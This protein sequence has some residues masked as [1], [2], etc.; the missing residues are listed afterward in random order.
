[1][2]L[3]H[4]CTVQPKGP[5]SLAA[6]RF[7]VPVRISSI[8]VFPAGAHPFANAPDIVAET[9]P[10]AFYIDVF[11]NAHPIPQADAKEKPR[12]PNA[13]V[14][15]LIAYAGG[16]VEYTVD[17][18]TEH[19]TRLMILKGK[20]TKLS[21]AIYGDVVSDV[22]P[23]ERHEARPLPSVEPV[24]LSKAIDPSSSSDPT[25]L[26]KKL[27]ALMPD[28]PPLPL[29][30]RLMFCLK[31]S[32]DD[33]DLPDF[34]YLHADLESLDD[35][36]LSIEAINDLLS[37]PVHD[38]VTE[39]E[40]SAFAAKVAECISS[41]KDSNDA[42]P[43]AR[44]FSI[45]A[46]QHPGLVRA[47]LRN[48]D[49][50]SFFTAQ[51]VDEETLLCL[52]QAASNVDIARHMNT[53]T[54]LLTLRQVQESQKAEAP[55]QKAARRLA[56]RI[57][58]WQFFEDSLT[59]TQGD[60][61]QCWN[62]L[63]DIGTEESSMAI[64]LETMITHDDIVA[65]MAKIPVKTSL[66][67]HFP[68]YFRSKIN[69][70]S[71]DAFIALVRTLI[72]VASVLAVWAWTDSVGNDKSRE[73]VSAVIH[74][75]QGV[76]GYREIVNHLLLL[77]QLARRLSWISSD[78]EI[79]RQSGILAE[80][81]ICELAKDPQAVLNDD[82][83]NTILQLKPKLAFITENELLSLRKIALVSDDGLPSAAEE[84][85]FSSDHPLS[86]RRL[87]TLRVSLA[88]VKRELVLPKGEWKILESL[89]EE[90]SPG[91]VQ[92][93]IDLLI[94]ISDDLNKQFAL[95]PPPPMNQAVAEQ[96]FSTADD[97]LQL[98]VQLA[99][100][101]P[102]TTRTMRRLVAATADIFACTDAA[103]TLFSQTSP[104]SLSARGTHQGC[105]DLVD[106]LSAAGIVA[107][108]GKTGAE[109]VLSALLQHAGQC[110]QRDPVLHLLQVFTLIDHILP[111]PSAMLYDEGEPSYWVT[112]VLPSVLDDLKAF[113]R[114]L[115]PENKLHIVK[116]LIR[117]DDG[118]LDIGAWLLAEEL[119][120]MT[121]TIMALAGRSR[122]ENYQLV[123]RYR[124]TLSLQFV[125]GLLGVESSSSK[126]ALDAIASTSSL[127]ATLNENL[128]ALLDGQYTST[129][130]DKLIEVLVT[131]AASFEPELQFTISLAA[132]RVS[133]KAAQPYTLI[134][135]IAKIVNGLT[136][137]VISPEPLRVELGPVFS[138]LAVQQVLEPET[139]QSA[140][141]LLQWL[142]SQQ[143]D[144]RL[145]VLC[146]VSP[147]SFSALFSILYVFL[148]TK[149]HD[150][151]ATLEATF[152]LDEN[153]HLPPPSIALPDT[154][155]LSIHDV[156]DLIRQEIPTPTTPSNG[157]K[158]PDILGI[159]ISPPTAV[160]RS[161]V[162]TTGL[163]KTYMN[164]DFR[165][166]RQTPS[167]RQN[168]SRLPSMHGAYLLSCITLSV[169]HVLL[170]LLI[171]LM[172][173]FLCIV[174]VG[175]DRR[176]EF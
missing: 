165:D 132:L 94:G 157:A 102:P 89:W 85:M 66:S 97:L 30:I 75:W 25:F 21:I 151:I 27:L 45:S 63:Q 118:V 138:A 161:Q 146:G 103:D 144:T 23:K 48:M 171:S 153:D 143:P 141:S 116:R 58:E 77:R 115:G 173:P 136:T 15:T 129:Y 140:L 59:N 110:G 7:A 130:L 62:M 3:L 6:V 122:K 172:L 166:L 152:T 124:V 51:H 10:E 160:L 37:R 47:L 137:N 52:L 67:S 1:M 55:T 170:W 106:M 57:A 119:K 26:A 84:L 145:T 46:S 82:L 117:L 158:T 93:L 20:F 99:P 19:A 76:D 81:I 174:D 40:L 92:C 60:F 156:D 123:L 101:Y 155:K 87:R 142:A 36:E 91:I 83:V 74:L 73:Q 35:E 56:D 5:D 135:A 64:W 13:L 65:K 120:E 14:P 163:T 39:E 154:L 100:V 126:W 44:L 113:L 53:E 70:T 38:E 79:P 105:L 107:E 8:C 90:G 139:A 169:F 175:I 80:K 86:L 49:F 72:G 149:D 54:F 17:M 162:E 112:S 31:P 32:N 41:P 24:P 148:P 176:L 134:G 133:G 33:W 95:F 43:V 4:W 168:T 12:V 50:N 22:P 18:G 96:L 167:A 28:A 125:L 11:L 98:I 121:T 16:Q 34:P 42:Y 159:I 127:S 2:G 131:S 147:D 78:N 61:N 29:V 68:L 69:L 104:A 164:N 128:M 111:E 114:L 109:I 88:I 108:P 9:E 71:H 150:T